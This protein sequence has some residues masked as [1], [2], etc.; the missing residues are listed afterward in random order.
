MPEPRR[1]PPGRR[2]TTT[3]GRRPRPLGSHGSPANVAGHAPRGRR[4]AGPPRVRPRGAPEADLRF[5]G[6]H[7]LG[8]PLL[9]LPH[10]TAPQFVERA[11]NQDSAGALIDAHNGGHVFI[12]RVL[13][14]S[15]VDRFAFTRA[16]KPEGLHHLGITHPALGFELRV[17]PS[18]RTQPQLA[19]ARLAPM[20]LA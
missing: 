5:P 6:W 19:P 13:K 15:Q 14:E 7:S 3:D 8:F 17:E 9:F 2:P 20:V 12:G 1:K 10:E 11:M 4:E 18:L 16:E